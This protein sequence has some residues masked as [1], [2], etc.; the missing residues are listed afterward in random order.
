M[1]LEI[2]IKREVMNIENN[3]LIAEFMGLKLIQE[4]E[5]GEWL[6]TGVEDGEE[7][8]G[9][10]Y[11]GGIPEYNASWEEL[12]PVVEKIEG[13]GYDTEIVYRLDDGLGHRFYINDSGV[14]SELCESKLEATYKAVVEFIKWYNE[15]EK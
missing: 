1:K 4:E 7:M 3:K 8:R 12:M 2:L 5:S 9:R 13:L 15:R 11:Y 14:H 10:I 6:V